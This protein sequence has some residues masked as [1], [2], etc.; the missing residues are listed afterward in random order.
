AVPAAVA[1]ELAEPATGAAPAGGVEQRVLDIVAEQTGY[2]PDLLDMDLD[3]EA[4]LG[5]DTVKQAEVFATIR[6]AYGIER[7]DALKLR[8]YPTLN[9]VVGFVRERTPQEA[10]AGAPPAA[11]EAPATTKPAPAPLEAADDQRFPRRIPVPVLRPPLDLCVPTGVTLGEGSRVVLMPDAAGAGKA[12]AER[13]KKLDAEV[14]TIDG[15]PDIETLEQQLAEWSAGGPIQGVFWLAGLDDEGPLDTLDAGAR[16]D[17]LHVRVKLLAAAMRALADERTFLVSATRLGGRHGYDAGGARG[18][19][20]GAVTGFTKA[21][22]QER[23]DAL[24]K[25]IDFDDAKPKAIAETLLNETLTDPGAVEIGHAEDLRWSVGL[26]EQAARHDAAREL[27][28]DTVFMVTGAAGSI[29]AAIIDDLAAASGGTF[30]LLD[31]VAAPDPADPD[32]EK[33]VSDREALGRELADRIREKGERP[34]PKL[35]ERELARI[36]RGRAALDAIGAIERA[37]GQAFW[38]QVDLTDADKVAAA[39]ADSGPIDVLLHCAGVEISHFLPDKPQREYDLVFDVK[40]HGWLNLLAA[41]GTAGNGERRPPHT[42]VVFSSIA[43]R[44]GNGGQTDYS[45]AND[46]LCKSISQMRRIGDTRGVAIDWTAWAQIGMASRGSIPK[47]MEA[48]GIDMLPPEVGIPVVRRELTAAGAGTEVV[49]AG[50]LGILTQER[51]ETGGLD[52]P[53]AS[54]AVAEHTGPMTGTIS[55]FARDGVLTVTTELDPTRQAF[56]YDHRIDGTPVLP[57]VMGMEAFA[58]IASVLV[59]GYKVIELADVEL[60]APFKFY[61]D[62]PRTAILRARLRASG[63]ERVL[64]ECELIG[65]RELRGKGEQETRHFTGLVRLARKAPSAP[66]A[67]G[68]PVE[69]DKQ[70]DGGVGREEVYRVL[71]HG[72]A[73]QVLEQ[74]WHDNGHIVGRLAAELP[75]D[76]EPPEQPMELAPRVIELCFQTAGVWELATAGRM[77]LPTHVDR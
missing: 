38:H 3:L 65:R 29:V 24:I 50:S 53:R 33:F 40:A 42:A 14:L 4:D 61:R 17:A 7:D 25:T 19:F 48:A 13:L 75:A 55:A 12:L 35:V 47:M 76:H 9:H 54:A 45:A 68:A 49:T 69:A 74:A 66:K 20:G 39:V 73:Y 58:E 57:G 16:R 71:F 36:E 52:V 5:I 32:L 37:G 30:H 59:P 60:L 18:I 44:F 10:E 15:A 46:L 72:P 21:L 1:E 26:V 6:E 64:A 56:L 23:P 63:D 41:L 8:D 22:S 34:T 11:D 70:A 51:H 28:K 62:E 2:P 43:G 31:L 67:S 27:T 77:G